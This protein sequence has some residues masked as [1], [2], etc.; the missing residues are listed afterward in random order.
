MSQIHFHR[1][2]ND[3]Q[4]DTEFAILSAQHASRHQKRI[5]F[6]WETF[7][8]QLLL[9]MGV[10]NQFNHLAIYMMSV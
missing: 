5:P 4:K 8:P 10:A 6:I 7:P 3:I 9:L 2:D 1:E